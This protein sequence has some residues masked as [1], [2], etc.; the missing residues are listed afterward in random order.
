MKTLKNI[1]AIV[2]IAVTVVTA[3]AQEILVK[4]KSGE[5]QTIDYKNYT[6]NGRGI[7][8]NNGEIINYIDV[9]SI[10]TG[11]YT[12]YE[13]AFRRSQRNGAKHI[14]VEFTGDKSVH[15]EKLQK[16]QNK[17][18][19]AHVA[20]GAGGLLAIIGAISGDRDLYNAGM[21]T[22]GVGTIAKDINTEK[23]IATQNQMLNELHQ[24]QNK[25]ESLEDQ[26]RNEYGNENVDAIIALLDN[27]H[28][29]AVA[30]A[31]AGET[32]KDANFRLSAMYVKAIIAVDMDN[33]EEADQAYE[34]LVIFDPEVADVKQAKEETKILVEELNNLRDSNS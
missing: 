31:N 2:L 28:N 15:L 25:E 9:A 18:D 34:K 16:L 11:N 12:A 6:I 32:S 29:R 30:L 14:K 4:L 22:Y 3:N 21:V 8:N 13:K 5:E 1:I 27:D 10:N 7:E 19:G 26:Y 24:N 17:R 33:Q 23:T 20:R